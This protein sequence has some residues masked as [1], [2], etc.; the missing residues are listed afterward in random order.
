MEKSWL[1]KFGLLGLILLIGLSGSFAFDVHS[2]EAKHT[3]WCYSSVSKYVDNDSFTEADL[4]S[5]G[6]YHVSYGSD[7]ACYPYLNNIVNTGTWSDVACVGLDGKIKQKAL[8]T[9][10][11]PPSCTK[12]YEYFASRIRP[13][14]ICKKC[15]N[16]DV[17]GEWKDIK[18]VGNELLRK[19]NIVAYRFGPEVNKC[20]SVDYDEFSLKKS[21]KCTNPVS[22]SIISANDYLRNGSSFLLI[23]FI[24]FFIVMVY[25]DKDYFL[26]RG[27]R[28]R[29]R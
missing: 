23:I 5:L 10:I 18:C 3:N 21:D 12:T 26:K 11:A 15:K 28:R 29:W 25:Y 19:R 7:C 4:N 6:I 9:K 20:Y 22:N 14:E 13:K 27:R 8:V 16:A 1:I 17:V 24:F 2:Q